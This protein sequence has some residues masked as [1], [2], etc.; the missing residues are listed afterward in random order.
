VNGGADHAVGVTGDPVLLD[1]VNV[2][3]NGEQVVCDDFVRL[4]EGVHWLG[5]DS[6]VLFVR[7]FYEGYLKGVLCDFDASRAGFR[8]FITCGTA[9]IG[10]SAFGVWLL[11]QAI[12]L[13]RTVVYQHEKTEAGVVIQGGSKVV[14]SIRVP[15]TTA[16]VPEL[17]DPNTGESEYLTASTTPAYFPPNLYV[18]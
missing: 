3:I 1:C 18:T 7:P 12:A 8:I 5:L 17:T 11:G 16:Q 2:L 14:R 6:S 9:G 10:K 15:C 13:N 4:P